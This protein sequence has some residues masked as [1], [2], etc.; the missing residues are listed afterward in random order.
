MSIFTGMLD[1]LSEH[2]AHATALSRGIRWVPG[3]KVSDV[4]QLLHE[5][6]DVG[7]KWK[8]FHETATGIDVLFHLIHQGG[9]QVAPEMRAALTGKEA[10]VSIYGI[11]SA[12]T[13][14]PEVKAWIASLPPSQQDIVYSELAGLGEGM[15]SMMGGSPYFEAGKGAPMAYGS[16][17]DI[18]YSTPGLTPYSPAGGGVM[19]FNGGGGTLS[20]GAQVV[21]RWTAQ[22]RPFIAYMQGNQKRIATVKNDGS[23]KTWAVYRPVVLGK[24]PTVRQARRVATKLKGW[25]KAYRSVAGVMG[26]T[27]QTKGAAQAK[28][29]GKRR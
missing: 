12:T 10:T 28:A 15:V 4:F 5:G 27:L 23:I 7:P 13:L 17:S 16:Q 24:N 25:L 3:T 21:R 11:Q 6:E 2:F 20:P 22:G 14:S 26:Y 9:Y 19:P 8:D 1:W 29:G 18:E